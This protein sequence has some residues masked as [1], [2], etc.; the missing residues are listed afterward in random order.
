M[1]AMPSDAGRGR[2][3]AGGVLVVVAV[4]TCVLAFVP[5]IAQDAAY[6]AFADTRPVLG[7]PNGWNVLSSLPFLAVGAAGV[8]VAW[9]S[10]QRLGV[11][12]PAWL[13]FFVAVGGVAVG[14]AA[15]H[16][17]PGNATLVWDR[18]PMGVA[19]MALTAALIGAQLGPAHG[20]RTLWPLLAAGVASVGYWHVSELAGAGDLRPY[21]LVQFLPL[22]ALPVL[23]FALP[24]PAGLRGAVA[25]LAAGYVV[26]K[27]FEAVDDEILALT[28]VV[29]GHALK[30]VSAAL[31]IVPLLRWL[32]AGAQPADDGPR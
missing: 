19:F 31:G 16:L 7:L 32:W 27:A 14:S 26:A 5:R 28:G 22:L 20:R 15:Y 24:A 6:H 11:L 23:V 25:W 13:L 10:R 9:R 2:L 21:A 1:N 17:A 4:A 30:H 12:L 8:V 18:M 3:L 29:A